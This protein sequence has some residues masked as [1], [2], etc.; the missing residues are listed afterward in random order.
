MT[1]ATSSSKPFSELMSVSPEIIAETL[2]MPLD[3]VLLCIDFCA[4]SIRQVAGHDFVFM[5][6]MF[7]DISSLDI[8][9]I[10]PDPYGVLHKFRSLKNVKF[11]SGELVRGS[12]GVKWPLVEEKPEYERV[13]YVCGCPAGFYD[14]SHG[15][16]CWCFNNRIKR[17]MVHSMKVII[18]P[19][20]SLCKYSESVAYGAAIVSK[21]SG[22]HLQQWLDLLDPR[23][24]TGP[25]EWYKAIS[26]VWQ[27][28]NRAGV[29][30]AGKVPLL[31]GFECMLPFTVELPADDFALDVYDWMVKP[32]DRV[33]TGPYLEVFAEGVMKQLLKSVD[34]SRSDD[35]E[36]TL[37][38]FVTDYV[39]S[40]AWV[41]QGG[42]NARVGRQFC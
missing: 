21:L 25:R 33:V 41:T 5:N 35:F 42:C 17:A 20:V 6:S 10:K 13:R 26:T 12:G 39:Y 2:K 23:K 16:S 40:G 27:E 34:L 7:V 1:M 36:G 28:F 19:D 22:M 24:F 3:V 14:E 32:R 37:E 4:S 9:A 11:D 38:E 15:I 30:L 18:P 29:K 31:Y 8:G